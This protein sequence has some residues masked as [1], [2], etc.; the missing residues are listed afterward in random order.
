LVAD[1]NE[2]LGDEGWTESIARQ[3][4]LE[5]PLRALGCKRVRFPRKQTSKNAATFH[6][7]Y[8]VIR[9]SPVIQLG[10]RSHGGSNQ[11]DADDRGCRRLNRL[12]QFQHR[13]GTRKKVLRR[14]RPDDRFVFSVGHELGVA[15]LAA[16]VLA[17]QSRMNLQ[18]AT[19]R[20]ARLCEVHW[21]GRAHYEKGVAESRRLDN[22]H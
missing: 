16:D 7:G 6:S 12:R 18:S 2:P 4:K 11:L 3:M 20:R 14:L 17:Q 1:R 15:V 8:R 5:S 21:H 9:K 13:L 10:F 19:T 22:R